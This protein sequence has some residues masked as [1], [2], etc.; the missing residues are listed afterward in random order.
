MLKKIR[1]MKEEDGFTLIELMVVVLI[2]AI[3]IAIALPTF[4]GLRQR[5]QDRAA[6]SNL[7]NGMAAAKAF[8]TD[9]ETYTGFDNTDGQAIEPSLGWVGNVAPTTG[10]V[11]VRVGANGEVLLASLSASG[12][13]FCIADDD[14][15]TKYDSGAAAGDV[16]TIAECVGTSW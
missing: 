6:Q 7:R 4:L 8:Y 10:Q 9:N 11:A 15:V 16:D 2:I 1:E 12:T 13:H 3:L 5:A 14:G